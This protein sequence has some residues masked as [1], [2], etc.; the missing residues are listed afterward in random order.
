MEAPQESL[1]ELEAKLQALEA[2]QSESVPAAAAAATAAAVGS[3]AS[4]NE[5]I[6]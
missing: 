1:G 4:V 3:G 5:E 6:L 2:S